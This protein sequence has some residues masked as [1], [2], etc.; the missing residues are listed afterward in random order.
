MIV[1]IYDIGEGI[2]SVAPKFDLKIR[3]IME[4]ISYGLNVYG[5]V[6]DRSLSKG[7]YENFMEK[8]FQS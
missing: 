5:S 3:R 2:S 4:K 7:I 6:D 1:N 8:S